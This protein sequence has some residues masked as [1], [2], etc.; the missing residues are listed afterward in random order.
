MPRWSPDKVQ[1]CGTKAAY[2]RHK[3]YG[4][5][6]CDACRQANR[7]HNQA[8][9]ATSPERRLKQIAHAKAQGRARS[10]LVRRHLAEYRELYAEE[11][12][13]EENR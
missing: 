10:R 11:L 9:Y 4:E 12:A 5:E 1:P 7:A 3:K 2:N 6:P 8:Q 13:R